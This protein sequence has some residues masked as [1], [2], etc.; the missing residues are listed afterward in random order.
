MDEGL[1][2]MLEGDCSEPIR[3]CIRK[4]RRFPFADALKSSVLL[5]QLEQFKQQRAG[6]GAKRRAQT[7]QV[8]LLFS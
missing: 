8:S 1:N 5:S 4:A 6:K 3:Q 7:Q 2:V